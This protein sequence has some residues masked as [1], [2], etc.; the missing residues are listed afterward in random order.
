MSQFEKDL[1]KAREFVMEWNRRNAAG[2]LS[3]AWLA[4]HGEDIE[5]V[6]DVFTVLDE[7]ATQFLAALR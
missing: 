1:K 4:E 3:G 5:N 7:S 6:I 2:N